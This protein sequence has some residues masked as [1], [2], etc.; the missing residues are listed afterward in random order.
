MQ[1]RTLG[2]GLT[3][4]AIGYGCMGLNFAY[5]DTPTEEEA[6]RLLRAAHAKGVTF[7]D[8]AEAYGPFENEKIVGRALEPIRDEVK[9]ATKFGFEDGDASAPREPRGSN[10]ADARQVDCFTDDTSD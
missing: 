3:V 7:F 6:I 2:Q 9:I 10:E 4:S 5:A 1:T 8:T